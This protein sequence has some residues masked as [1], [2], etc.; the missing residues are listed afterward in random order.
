MYIKNFFFWQADGCCC[1]CSV[2]LFIVGALFIALGVIFGYYPDLVI[3]VD[4]AVYYNS[5]FIHLG[6]FQLDK[7]MIAAGFF[8]CLASIVRC[9]PCCRAFFHI[10]AFIIIFVC[11]IIMSLTV[12][13]FDDKAIN[14]KI[15]NNMK[16]ELQA[17]ENKTEGSIWSFIQQDL[18][19]CGIFNSSDWQE[20]IHYANGS[21][22]DS[23]CKNVTSSCGEIAGPEDIYPNGCLLLFEDQ[24]FS[25]FWLVVVLLSS[26]CVIGGLVICSCCCQ[27]C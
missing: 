5:S 1:C 3:S 22:P 7:I 25:S 8:M 21:V 17:F 18:Q 9:Y 19:C 24:I 12:H 26:L 11:I 2:F 16:K 27:V 14:D 23:C 4:S 10:I 15:E 6:F 13:N 20:N